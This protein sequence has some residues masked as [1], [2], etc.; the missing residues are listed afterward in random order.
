MQK[1]LSALTINQPGRMSQCLMALCLSGLRLTPIV[2][3]IRRQRRHPAVTEEHVDVNQPG[4]R[5]F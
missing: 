4:R 1:H 3:R 2:G 5:R